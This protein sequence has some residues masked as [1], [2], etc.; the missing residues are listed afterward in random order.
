M[1][2]HANINVVCVV[3]VDLIVME[4]K[5]ANGGLAINSTC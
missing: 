3:N 5:E 4:E 2:Q 1:E